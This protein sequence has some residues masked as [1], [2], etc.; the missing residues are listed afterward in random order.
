MFNWLFS[1]THSI[2]IIFLFFN[3]FFVFQVISYSSWDLWHCLN[4]PHILFYPHSLFHSFSQ[5]FNSLSYSHTILL[6]CSFILSQL[7]NLLRYQ[8]SPSITHSPFLIAIVCYSWPVGKNLVIVQY[9]SIF[10]L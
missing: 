4:F 9:F 10:S 3:I 1:F 8:F 6:T 2:T 5:L 7:S